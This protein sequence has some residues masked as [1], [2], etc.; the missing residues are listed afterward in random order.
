M[1]IV[2]VILAAG[3]CLRCGH[4]HVSMPGHARV[5]QT[6]QIQSVDG[7]WLANGTC[8]CTYGQLAATFKCMCV[9][10]SDL[11]CELEGECAQ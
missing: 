4:V 7:V 6:S 1:T 9:R 10:K 11:K 5:G 8:V 2:I 3:N